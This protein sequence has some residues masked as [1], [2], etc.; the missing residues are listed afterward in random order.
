[1]A[2][3]EPRKAEHVLVYDAECPFCSRW[4]QALARVDTHATLRYAT[5]STEFAARLFEQH[6]PLRSIETI[7]FV[8]PDR[9]SIR[10]DGAL[11]GALAVGGRFRLLAPLLLIPRFIRDPI[12][13]QIAKYRRRLFGQSGVCAIGPD[14]ERVKQRTLP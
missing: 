7:I 3:V 8:A 9:I 13:N 5:R 10:S 14:A 1:M 12:Y 2:S 4:V 11:R 6:P